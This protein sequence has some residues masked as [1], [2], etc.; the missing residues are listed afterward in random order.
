LVGA[1]LY[2][3]AQHADE[4]EYED[5]SGAENQYDRP[6]DVHKPS[7]ILVKGGRRFHFGLNYGATL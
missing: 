4:A 6:E 5:D 2:E 1:S 7:G 3:V